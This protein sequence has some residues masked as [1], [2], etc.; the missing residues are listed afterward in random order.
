M[1]HHFFFGLASFECPRHNTA[2]VQGVCNQMNM[3]QRK[4]ISTCAQHK[5]HQALNACHSHSGQ[6]CKGPLPTTLRCVLQLAAVR[7]N[8]KES[9]ASFCQKMETATPPFRG[10]PLQPFRLPVRPPTTFTLS[11]S[12]RSWGFCHSS[13][14]RACQNKSVPTCWKATIFSPVNSLDDLPLPAVHGV[15]Q[16]Q[17]ILPKSTLLK[18]P[19][20]IV[21][22]RQ[23]SA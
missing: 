20:R 8:C 4:P 3:F 2:G 17:R 11:R 14:H 7:P 23:V 10:F 13:N 19:Q 21:Q 18:G 9:P 15:K 5:D 12:H 22:T 6:V 16:V 1:P